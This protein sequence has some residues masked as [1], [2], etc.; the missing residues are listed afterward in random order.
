MDTECINNMVKINSLTF[1]L[2]KY[3]EAKKSPQNGVQSLGNKK[4]AI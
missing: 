4:R 3:G 2:K 1:E